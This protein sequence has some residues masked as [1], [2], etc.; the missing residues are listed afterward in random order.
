MAMRGEIDLDPR[1]YLYLFS[2]DGIQ[3][4]RDIKKLLETQ[5]VVAD[6]HPTLSG[7]VFQL[8]YHSQ[9]AVSCVHQATVCDGLLHPDFLF[10][11]DVPS[12]VSMERI[13]TRMGQ[14]DLVFEDPSKLEQ[15]RLLY[16][17][18]ARKENA[19]VLNGQH[20]VEKL[21]AMVMD[22]VGIA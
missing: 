15:R 1:T 19:V 10:V 18:L 9:L 14:K 12:S 21:V 16:L 17:E 2:A 6:R 4:D 11:I 3:A 22:H 13:A 8:D 7:K 5:H 20:S